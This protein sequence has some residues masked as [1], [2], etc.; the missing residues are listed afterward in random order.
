MTYFQVLLI[1]LLSPILVLGNHAARDHWRAVRRCGHPMDWK[2]FMAI[3]VLIVLALVYTTPWDNYLVATG[4]WGYDPGRVSGIR[5]GWVPIEEYVFF[6]LQTLLTGLWVIFLRRYRTLWARPT[7]SMPRLRYWSGALVFILW[8]LSLYLLVSGWQPGRYLGLILSWA[9]IPI[10]IQVFFG[11]DI[12]FVNAG[13]VFLAVAPTTLY[14]W[15]VDALSIRSRIW[16]ISPDQTTGLGMGYLPLE[17]MVFFFMTN[18]LISIGMILILS[19]KSL[20][21]LQAVKKFLRPVIG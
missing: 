3:V 5:L 15:I 11:G 16:F 13:L 10:F 20:E 17:E 4:V 8:V 18:L 12:L 14:L 7:P 6:I 9:L 21:R 19:P 2:P 1:F